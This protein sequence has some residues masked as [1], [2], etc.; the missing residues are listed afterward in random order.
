LNGHPV[1][2]G[3]GPGPWEAAKKLVDSG[4]FDRDPALERFGATFN[5]GGFL[6]RVKEP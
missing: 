3:F 1:W 6:K 5:A 4:E 2:A